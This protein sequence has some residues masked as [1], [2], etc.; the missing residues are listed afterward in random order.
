M[1]YYLLFSAFMLQACR[2]IITIKICKSEKVFSCCLFCSS[3]YNYLNVMRFVYI[4]KPLHSD[5]PLIGKWTID[6]LSF[7]K[8]S[9]DLSIAYLFLAMSME[10]SS[11]LQVEFENDSLITTKT[12]Q[13]IEKTGYSFDI[14]TSQVYLKDSS[15]TTFLFS[16][17]NDS[18]ISL[19]QKDSVT[20][21]L[22]RE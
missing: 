14:A 20:L 11:T 7:G 8:D 9:N 19:S 4:D 3:H 1:G 2:Y 22:K 13:T 10:D 12:T 18:L 6:S 21:Y 15:R 16:R 5:N 17:I